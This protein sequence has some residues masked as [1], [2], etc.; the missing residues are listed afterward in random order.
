MTALIELMA[1]AAPKPVSWRSSGQ[2]VM[3]V[4]LRPVYNSIEVAL[5]R[6]AAARLAPRTSWQRGRLEASIRKREDVWQEAVT[7]LLEWLD[8]PTS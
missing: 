5:R 4:K 8:F 2:S 6:S 3:T 1:R 7:V